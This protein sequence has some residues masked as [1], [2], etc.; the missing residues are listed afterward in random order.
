MTGMTRR[1]F[2]RNCTLTVA[3]VSPAARAV[4]GKGL[5]KH[6][7]VVFIAYR[8][9]GE[10]R[11]TIR[12]CLLHESGVQCVSDSAVHRFAARYDGGFQQSARLAEDSWQDYDDADASS[13]AWV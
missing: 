9:A 12:E 4:K 13:A 7:N 2:L 8:S 6:P 11:G 3:A 1:E 10:R 5:P